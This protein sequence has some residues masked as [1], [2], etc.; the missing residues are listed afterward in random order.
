MVS[1][2]FSDML[3][4]LY[5]PDH[6][7][8]DEVTWYDAPAD[9]P[10]E[11]IEE[12]FDA[13]KDQ[14]L[15]IDLVTNRFVNNPERNYWPILPTDT[16]KNQIAVFITDENLPDD[17]PAYIQLQDICAKLSKLQENQGRDMEVEDRTINMMLQKLW[18][19]GETLYEP[20][21][22]Y[23]GS[24]YKRKR[25]LVLERINECSRTKERL[26]T[27]YIDS[28]SKLAKKAR[29]ISQEW[30]REREE[31]EEELAKQ[32][33]RAN[34][35]DTQQL[36][37]DAWREK[38]VLEGCLSVSQADNEL[39]QTHLNQFQEGYNHLRRVREGVLGEH[40]QIINR[41]IEERN[42]ERLRVRTL[43]GH[44]RT[45]REVI[46]LERRRRDIAREN[47][48]GLLRSLDVTRGELAM[49]RRDLLEARNRVDDLN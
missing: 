10:P 7:F 32:Q 9:L 46:I 33:M 31:S 28:V 5:H 38:A 17:A 20:D 43:K 42:N 24:D 3:K 4:S 44:L 35:S 49:T 41:A 27:E 1:S 30:K 8:G 6:I 11:E 37:Q 14:N 26:E 29:A 45:H 48:S 40:N 21:N 15:C 18:A 25:D 12:Y 34:N 19:V 22:I 13:L 36:L 2:T 16:V 23:T 39:L 47:C